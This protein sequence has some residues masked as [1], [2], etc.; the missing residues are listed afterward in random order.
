MHSAVYQLLD[1]QV[2]HDPSVGKTRVG[3][4]TYQQGGAEGKRHQGHYE[5]GND[6]ERNGPGRSKAG[7][8]F[9]H[10]LPRV[11]SRRSVLSSIFF[12]AE[13]SQRTRRFVEI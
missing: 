8:L 5:G 6:Q 12:A 3:Q 11:G 9:L 4:E 1:A 2:R 7:L 10:L 13:P